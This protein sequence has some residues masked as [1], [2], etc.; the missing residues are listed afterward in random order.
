MVMIRRACA[1]ALYTLVA[2]LP[3][4]AQSS[5][6]SGPTFSFP[7][8][9][10]SDSLA[11]R[12]RALVDRLAA[13]FN[14]SQRLGDALSSIPR[15]RFVPDYLRNL[16][17]E[18]SSLPLGGGQALPSPSD[19]V[20][21]EEAL[22]L[23]PTDSLL[24]Y[25][26]DTGYTAALYSR[27]VASV[28]VI[29]LDPREARRNAQI[30]ASLGIANITSSPG[31]AEGSFAKNAPFTKILVHGAVGEI[32]RALLEEL[33]PDGRLVAPLADP[34]GFQMLVM[35]TNTS[36]T[37]TIQSVGKCFFPAMQVGGGR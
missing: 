33:S 24:I 18:D 16:A 19:L 13:T 5:L 2:L 32:P 12:R 1:L 21:I 37:L 25:G 14:I 17:Y 31:S 22:A 36:P 7:K 29:D 9:T 3:L 20:R 35:I 30:F 6:P 23:K 10:A 28:S 34:S 4:E 27:L 8:L 26:R 11:D 15:E